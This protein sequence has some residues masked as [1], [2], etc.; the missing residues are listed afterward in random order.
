MRERPI[1]FSGPMVRAILAGT[2]TQ[3]RRVAK[4]VR[5][6]GWKNV[7]DPGVLAREPKHTVDLACPYG[8]PGDRLWVRESWSSDFANQ[9]PHDHVWYAADDDRRNDIEVRDGVRGIYSPES[10]QFVRF[11]W[12]PSIH[13]LRSACRLML[14]IA[15]IRL[16]RLQAISEADACA[17]GIQGQGLQFYDGRPATAKDAFESMWSEINGPASWQANPWVWVLEF[18][19]IR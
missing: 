16:E 4:P 8:P 19:R 1:L 6:P 11:R 13:M 12:R 15:G 5:H 2:K 3:T 14:E 18:R 9:Y 17:E 7:Y 10:Q